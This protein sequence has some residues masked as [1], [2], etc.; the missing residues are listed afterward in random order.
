MMHHEPV[1]S[2]LKAA[3]VGRITELVP[4]FYPPG[5]S[6]L[7]NANWPTASNGPWRKLEQ[8]FRQEAFER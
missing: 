3:P 1:K 4:A 8:G 6:A 2:Q 7:G 5:S